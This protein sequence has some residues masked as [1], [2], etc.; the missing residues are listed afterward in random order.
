[1]VCLLRFLIQIYL[2]QFLK[3]RLR[4]HIGLYNTIL[5]NFKLP[6]KHSCST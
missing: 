2:L 5:S 1:M 4:F 6:P 3:I